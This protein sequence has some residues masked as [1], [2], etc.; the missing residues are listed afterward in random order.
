MSTTPTASAGEQRGILER[1]GRTLGAVQ[2]LWPTAL[3][4]S[5]HDCP[6]SSRPAL[7]E[8][9]PVLDASLLRALGA[10][11]RADGPARGSLRWLYWPQR[12]VRARGKWSHPEAPRPAGHPSATHRRTP[13]LRQARV[14]RWHT[15]PPCPYGAQ[16]PTR[17]RVSRADQF[18]LTLPLRL[19]H[20]RQAVSWWGGSPS[21][22]GGTKA[23]K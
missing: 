13:T 6:R 15:H 18:R 12:E 20:S 16:S 9:P 17:N 8:G 22:S 10:G 19:C 21:H 3:A 7:P 23:A 4:G 14:G 2:A 1:A 5:P 11:R